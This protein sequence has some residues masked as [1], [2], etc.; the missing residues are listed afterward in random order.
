MPSIDYEKQF[1]EFFDGYMTAALWSS[2]DTHPESGEDVSLD[3][4]E[5]SD[6][7]RINL[8]PS[9]YEFF[10]KH[11]G[12]LA[13]YL[14]DREGVETAS[15]SAWELAGH[16][17]WLNRNGHGTGFWDCGSKV[18]DQLA[19]LVGFKTEF[20]EINLILCD[21]LYVYC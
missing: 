16:D 14:E 4:F 13:L 3:Q 18:G 7:L 8:Q 11:Y 9:A 1:K 10:K 21:D 19:A 12:L 15:C 17:F 6:S 5:E 2:T 20:P